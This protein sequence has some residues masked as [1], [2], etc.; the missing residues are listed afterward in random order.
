MYRQEADSHSLSISRE[1][2]PPRDTFS[3]PAGNRVGLDLQPASVPMTARV[4][5]GFN[6]IMRNP[7]KSYQSSR[8]E[9]FRFRGAHKGEIGTSQTKRQSVVVDDSEH[10]C[11]HCGL[12]SSTKAS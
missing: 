12:T 6:F 5:D 2:V 9:K 7:S 1:F 8:Y 10:V 11:A 3:P 4:T